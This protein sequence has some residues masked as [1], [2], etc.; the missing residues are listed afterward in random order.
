MDFIEITLML[1]NKILRKNYWIYWKKEIFYWSI[2]MII[3]I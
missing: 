3:F 1:W 2:L